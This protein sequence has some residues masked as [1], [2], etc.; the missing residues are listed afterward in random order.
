MA[1]PIESRPRGRPKAFHDTTDQNTV[2]SLDRAMILLEILAQS[3]GLTL[4]DLAHGF[5]FNCYAGARHTLN[6]G[7]HLFLRWFAWSDFN[8]T[9][10]AAV[11]MMEQV[12]HDAGDVFRS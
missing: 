9:G 12:D 10:K 2:Q 6:D 1:K 8:A 11:I 4:S 3:P 7:S 5:I